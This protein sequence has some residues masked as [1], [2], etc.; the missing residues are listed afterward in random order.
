MKNRM[1]LMLTLA[2][3]VF[4]GCVNEKEDKSPVD[5]GVADVAYISLQVKTEKNEARSSGENAGM[6]ESD[7]N[8]KS[9]RYT[10]DDRVLYQDRECR[11]ETGCHQNLGG[12]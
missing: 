1:V 8:G 4:V 3:I 12:L 10:Q 11:F 5:G 6:N 2:A 7:L 9:G